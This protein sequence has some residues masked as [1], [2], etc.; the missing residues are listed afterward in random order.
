[1]KAIT[2]IPDITITESLLLLERRGFSS[3]REIEP[4]S[5]FYLLLLFVGEYVCLIYTNRIGWIMEGKGINNRF[6]TV[7]FA[8]CLIVF[9]G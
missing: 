5:R 2:Q 6:F 7:V 4:I 8:I 3:A 1:M 9:S